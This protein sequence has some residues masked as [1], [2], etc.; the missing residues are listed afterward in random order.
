MLR[1]TAPPPPSSATPE[2][3]WPPARFFWASSRVVA[4]GLPTHY[5]LPPSFNDNIQ[6]AAACLIARRKAHKKR[7]D[8]PLPM[9]LLDEHDRL[10]QL[11][12]TATRAMRGLAVVHAVNGL[13][14]GKKNPASIAFAVP[15][16]TTLLDANEL[17]ALRVL[18]D[19]DDA[20]RTYL[21]GD[22]HASFNSFQS[23]GRF[24][25]VLRLGIAQSKARAKVQAQRSESGGKATKAKFSGSQAQT[26]KIAESLL[27]KAK[28]H[29][30]HRSS[31]YWAVKK[32]YLHY[33]TQAKA[34]MPPIE[35]VSESAYKN[36]LTQLRTEKPELF[37]K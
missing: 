34:Q 2:E 12:D 18:A 26:R 17:T 23:A 32:T 27:V 30:D 3:D 14:S 6:E 4:E 20:I 24:M 35:P 1:T 36:V 29:K 5:A 10:A 7:G 8:E 31:V 9:E 37:L 22:F 33:V 25:S 28:A 15:G 21:I 13:R 11:A 19:M 16:T